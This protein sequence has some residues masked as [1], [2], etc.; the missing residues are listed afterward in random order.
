MIPLQI[1]TPRILPLEGR[2][3][4]PTTTLS[5]TTLGQRPRPLHTRSWVRLWRAWR[6]F[7]GYDDS[8]GA[9][10][11]F[12]LV[13]FL[14]PVSFP[15][16]MTRVHSCL[17]ESK[18]LL[19]HVASDFETQIVVSLDNFYPTITVNVLH[20]EW[21]ALWRRQVLKLL[22]LLQLLAISCD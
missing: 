21:P 8:P 6:P 2:R 13:V 1:A 18:S 17:E 12:P 19:P 16:C 4:P 15:S 10:N 11:A 9:P 22:F 5:A 3:H 20:D 7:G 14:V